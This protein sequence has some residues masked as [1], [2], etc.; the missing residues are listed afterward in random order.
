MTGR[1][2]FFV[3]A[4]LC[5]T[6]VMTGSR[7]SFLLFHALCLLGLI[8]LVS[9]AGLRRGDAQEESKREPALTTGNT[10]APK[11]TD[12]KERAVFKGKPAAVN[13]NNHPKAK[14]FRT[15]LHAG[16]AKG[17]NFAGHY[18][19]ITWGCGTE[20]Q[21]LGIVDAKTGRVFI[22]PFT[23]RLRANFRRDSRLL[24]ADPPEEWRSVYGEDNLD[25]V[26]AGPAK[27][28]YYRWDGTRLHRITSLTVT[29]AATA[30]APKK[31]AP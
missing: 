5:Y 6:V 16:A 27:A 29:A 31:D 25:D 24:I 1:G 14:Q 23:L 2:Y 7:R 10:P 21:M 17:P 12:Y 3:S 30:S 13:V 11:F 26:P 18:T 22:A 4:P 28:T 9:G 15:V 8:A 20:C 19:A